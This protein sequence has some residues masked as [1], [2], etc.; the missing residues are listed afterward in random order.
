MTNQEWRTIE[1]DD[2]F[3]LQFLQDARLSPDGK[4]IAYNLSHVDESGDKECCAVWLLSP[5]TGEARQLTD[6]QAIDSNLS[7]SPDGQKIAFFSTR[8]GVKQLYTIAVDGGESRMLTDLAQ[9]VGRG[10]VWCPDGKHIAFSARATAEPVYPT[11]PYRVTRKIY[12]LDGLGFLHNAVHDLFIV[13][14]A[15]GAARNLTQDENHKCRY[16]APEWSPDSQEILFTTT[17]FP[18]EHRFFASLR[19]ANLDGEV[20]DLVRDWGYAAYS[21]VWSPDRARVIFVLVNRL[22]EK[23]GMATIW[24]THDLGVVAGLVDRVIVMYA[25]FIVESASV[26]DLYKKT[27][28]PY[29]LGLLQSIPSIHATIATD[30]LIPIEGSPPDLLLEPVHCPF[31]QRCKFA[32]EKCWQKNPPLQRVASDHDAVCWRWEDVRAMGASQ[33]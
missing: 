19:V 22:R 29:T 23:F 8:S 4:Q 24:I 18:D 13:P 5:R 6:G 10:P 27:S 17:F 25:G 2:L 33:R 16:T 21:A 12:R 3:R 28:H 15:G 14:A 11:K 1:P 31:A 7:W 9:G 20:R 26:L 32:V 30:R